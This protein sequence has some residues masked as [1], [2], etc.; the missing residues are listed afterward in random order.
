MAATARLQAKPEPGAGTPSVGLTQAAET[1]V[2]GPGLLPPRSIS[3]NPDHKWWVAVSEA[4]TLVPDAVSQSNGCASRPTLTTYYRTKLWQSH[5]FRACWAR[6]HHHPPSQP[7]PLRASGPV[8]LLYHLTAHPP[9]SSTCLGPTG[10]W[11][12]NQVHWNY[13]HQHSLHW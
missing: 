8:D 13:D 6:L 4:G 11:A 5:A 9:A 7:L 2:P 3:K 12:W 10:V 1:Q